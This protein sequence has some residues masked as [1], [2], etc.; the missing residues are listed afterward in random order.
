M[1]SLVLKASVVALACVTLMGC[2]AN[3]TLNPTATAD[4]QHALATGCPIL[5]G[6]QSSRLPF[7][8]YQESALNT[9]ALVCPPN[10]PPTSAL[11]AVADIIA[12]YTTL[13]PLLNH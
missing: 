13:Q 11:V 1:H 3:V 8:K 4:L 2:A 6:L 10:P 12:A 9:L 7:D 5:A